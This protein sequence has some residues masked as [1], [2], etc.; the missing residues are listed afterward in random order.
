MKPKIAILSYGHLTSI[1]RSMPYVPPDCFVIILKEALLEDALLIAQDLEKQ[2]DSV[3]F[4]TGGGNAQLLLKQLKSP[5]VDIKI[6]G[7]DVLLALRQA[8]KSDTKVAIVTYLSKIPYL[9]E[10]KNI[11]NIGIVEETYSDMGNLDSV[12]KTLKANG[13]RIVIGASLVQEV[14][15]QNGLRSI[16]I[17]SSDGVVRALETAVSI[18]ISIDAKNKKAEELRTILSSINQGI[19]AIN[20]SGMITILNKSAAEI[21]GISQHDCIGKHVLDVIPNAYLMQVLR[22]GN[23][24]LNQIKSFG[25]GHVLTNN[26]PIVLDQNVVGAVATLQPVGTIQKAEA[27]IR[28]TLYEKGF[29]AKWHL[30]EI[31]GTSAPMREAR[32]TARRYAQGDTTVCIFGE[33]GT[34]K[35][36]F[37]QGIHNAGAR[38]AQP[39]VAVNCGAI[40]ETLLESELFGYEEGAFTGAKKGGKLGLFELAHNGT[41]FLDEIG[42]L[43][44]HLQARLLRVLET[45]EVLRVGGD[46]LIPINVRV[47]AATNKHLWSMIRNGLFREDLYYRINI[48]ELFLPALREHREDV[49]LLV[50]CFVKD[51]HPTHAYDITKCIRKHVLLNEYSWPGNVRD[52]RNVIER[53][54][55]LYDGQTE[56]QLLLGSILRQ[57]IDFNAQGDQEHILAAGLTTETRNDAAKRLGIS[58]TTLWRHLKQAKIQDR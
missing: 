41:I 47:I 12:I 29:S 14:A 56:P 6:T 35:D 58:R 15:E 48:L 42:E 51:F 8:A 52:L 44:V 37:A 17:Y 3:V 57:K 21:T 38:A 27:K 53:F 22:T 39:F 1:V 16:S 28:I 5:V 31:L 49:P 4:L 24:E 25:K 18:A 36:L 10:V 50:D 9:E 40:P 19:I 55:T 45:K 13:V 20:Q 2:N 30:D 7:F 33:S 32:E 43:P 34:G 26:V 11:I 23:A 54:C 46:R